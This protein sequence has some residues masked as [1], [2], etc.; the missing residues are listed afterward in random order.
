MGNLSS[1]GRGALPYHSREAINYIPTIPFAFR[2][3]GETRGRSRRAFRTHEKI[4]AQFLAPQSR[5]PPHKGGE[6][7][8]T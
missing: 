3:K 8:G 4:P 1:I 6:Q 7:V 5:T 2:C